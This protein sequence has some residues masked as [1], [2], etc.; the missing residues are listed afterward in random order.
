MKCIVCER[1]FCDSDSMN[2]SGNGY[3]DNTRMDLCA[4]FGF[5]FSINSWREEV[6]DFPPFVL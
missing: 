6:E 4:S 5:V 1:R 2:E 3:E